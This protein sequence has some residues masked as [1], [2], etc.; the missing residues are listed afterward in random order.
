MAKKKRNKYESDKLFLIV[1]V[2]VVDHI[3]AVH[4]GLY[5]C[6][7]DEDLTHHDLWPHICHK[8]WRWSADNG[9]ELSTNTIKEEDKLDVEDFDKIIRHIRRKYAL[10]VSDNGIHE[11]CCY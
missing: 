5:I 10:R 9:I 6:G 7:E 4:S 2:G 3:G 11:D 1:I 8:K